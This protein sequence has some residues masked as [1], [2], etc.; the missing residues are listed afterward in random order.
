M[1][2]ETWALFTLTET[3]LC[4]APGPAVLLVLSEGL[5]HGTRKSL[6]SSGGILGANAILVRLRGHRGPSER[7]RCDDGGGVVGVDRHAK[8][9]Q[10]HAAAT[11]HEFFGSI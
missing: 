6:A 4:F 1:N 5:A 8:R 3:V 10:I 11:I 2:W 7:R 9:L